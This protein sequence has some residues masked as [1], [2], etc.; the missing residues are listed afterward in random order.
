MEAAEDVGFEVVDGAAV[1]VATEL[2]DPTDE[3][4]ANAVDV[5][6]ADEN[7]VAEIL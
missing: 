4:D 2:T 7:D 1:G 3:T 6:V 5:E